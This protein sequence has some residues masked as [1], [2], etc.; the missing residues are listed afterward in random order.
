MNPAA[1]ASDAPLVSIGISTFNRLAS[2]FPEALESALAQTYPRLEVVVC[3]N[4]SEDG[5][6]AFMAERRDPRVR[7]HRHPANIG[8]N[9]NFNA[10][11]DLATGA[12]FLLLH[13]DDLLDPGFVE[14]AVEAIGDGRPGVALAGVR[15]IDG[16]GR[17]ESE[18]ASPP[19]GLGGA[20]LFAA[21]FERR[22]SFYFCSTLFHTESLRELG[23][24]STPEGLF[25]DVVAIARLASRSGYAGVPGAGGSFRR[26]DANRGGASHALRWVRDSEHL[27]AVLR[28]EF[29]LEAE[30]L[31]R[32]GNHYLAAKC[33]RYVAGVRSPI[34]R[35]RLY[36]EIDRRFDHAYAPH[37]YLVRHHRRRLR[38]SAGQWLRSM[39]SLLSTNS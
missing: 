1:S 25:Q 33:Y 21:W 23:G 17:V 7:Y 14:R 6:H 28:E 39:R 5:T 4:A 10:C 22:L 24:F 34:E 30:R 27:L 3:D 13:D 16:E 18:V 12:Y 15:V 26:H 29:P 11:L 38:T 36:C 9:A 8:A 2:T 37:A 31:V 32:L 20:G 35:L 19:D